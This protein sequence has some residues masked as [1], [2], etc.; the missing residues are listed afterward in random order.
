MSD[1]AVA[2]DYLP[3]PLAQFVQRAK[4]LLAEE[5]EKP[6]P[7][8]ALIGFLCDAVRLA[9]ENNRL[10][11]GAIP[12]QF[13]SWKFQVL[14]R[15]H[16]VVLILRGPNMQGASLDVAADS[17]RAEVL[18]EFA[19][20]NESFQVAVR[21][22]MLECHG[23]KVGADKV[24]RNHRFLEESLELVQS[25]DCTASEAHQLVDYVYSRPM[26]K[27]SQETGGVM[28]TLAALCDANHLDMTECA[29]V[30]LARV[31]TKITEIRA[32]HAAKPVISP[33]STSE[34]GS[35][36]AAT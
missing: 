24:Q 36:T 3:M 15:A 7:D 19:N 17:I 5:Q 32:K 35:D 16:D 29:E 18:R 14:E 9:R 6:L 30:E 27:P 26:G 33:L 11:G 31:W 10:G 34:P 22:W 2:G 20:D 1:V 23:A 12:T 4:V 8:N 21:K 13:A 25:L 28:V